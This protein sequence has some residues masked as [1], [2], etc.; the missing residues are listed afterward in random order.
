M[1]PTVGRIVH[2][3]DGVFGVYAG[4]IT[5][6]FPDGRCTLVLFHKTPP[7]ELDKPV[8]YTVAHYSETPKVGHWSWP[9]R[10]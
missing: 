3:E 1:K 8:V 2:F 10:V 4:I 6:I 9:P 7:A 5:G